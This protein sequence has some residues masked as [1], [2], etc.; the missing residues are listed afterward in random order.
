[1]P[2]LR[3]LNDSKVEAFLNR[4]AKTCRIDLGSGWAIKL[5]RELNRRHPKDAVIAFDSLGGHLPEETLAQLPHREPTA[6][7]VPRLLVVRDIRQT[8]LPRGVADQVFWVM[9]SPQMVLNISRAVLAE[10]VR[11]LKPGA[12][13]V[14]V[15]E[16]PKGNTSTVE[17]LRRA[18]ESNGLRFEHHGTP[19]RTYDP[20]FPTTPF[21]RFYE[22]KYKGCF[23]YTARADL[24]RSV[25]RP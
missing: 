3:E 14:V 20:N 2:W 25:S 12:E 7:N 11:L 21:I 16:E 4:G 10:A 6:R 13:V 5:S 9:P 19:L 17:A 24:G 23:A 15:F 1:M 8:G 22:R 18:F